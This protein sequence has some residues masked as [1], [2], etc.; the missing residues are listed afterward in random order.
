MEGSEKQSQKEMKEPQAESKKL[1][2]KEFKETRESKLEIGRIQQVYTPT[3][4]SRKKKSVIRPISSREKGKN[5]KSSNIKN[6]QQHPTQ[7][8]QKRQKT[9]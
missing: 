3:K 4:I 9:P 5:R 6:K 7:Q 1:S 8:T 2:Q